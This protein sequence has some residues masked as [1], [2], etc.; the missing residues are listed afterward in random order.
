M[1]GVAAGQ[2]HGQEVPS[3]P[4]GAEE[5]PQAD[6]VLL[7]VAADR[8]PQEAL[9][10]HAQ[11]PGGSHRRHPAQP[12]WHG[13]AAAG[14]GGGRGGHAA[15]GAGR[16]PSAAAV[17]ATET[18]GPR[19][20]HPRGAAGLL[21]ADGGAPRVAAPRGRRQPVR[22]PPRRPPRGQLR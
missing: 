19:F 17:A 5:K 14:D 11:E 13:Y 16:R 12:A 8:M 1:R 6:P 2:V 21:R 9:P 10:L 20:G 22:A 4:H 3:P 15:R 18:S 7:G